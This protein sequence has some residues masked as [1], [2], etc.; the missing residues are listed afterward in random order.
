MDYVIAAAAG[1]AIGFLL[2]CIIT[3]GHSLEWRYRADELTCRINRVRE[4]AD[5]LSGRNGSVRKIV[6]MLGD[7]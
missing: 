4:Y 5:T 6:R 3:G 1:M 2:A 7:K